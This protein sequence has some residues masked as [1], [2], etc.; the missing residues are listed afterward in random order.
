M[1]KLHSFI[2]LFEKNS[3]LIEH[4][5][6]GNVS[7]EDISYNS[8]EVTKNTLF[9][10]KGA[11]FK[12]QFLHDAINKGAV[13]Y[14]STQ[15][16]DADV[17]CIIVSDIRKA[18]YSTANF[19]YKNAWNKLNLIGITGTKGKSTTAYFIKHILDELLENN[20]GKESGIASTPPNVLKSTHLPSITGIPASGPI[21]PSPKTAVP[22][23]IT[24]TRFPLAVKSNDLL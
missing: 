4:N 19:F 18:L 10:C 9:F 1:E 2:D 7:V 16:Y 15:K 23:V 24:A 22:S 11:H 6:D 14:V 8:R 5:C 20:Q 12:E 3:I 13:A 17:P 21:S